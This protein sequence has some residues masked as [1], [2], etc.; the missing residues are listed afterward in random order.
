M[1]DAMYSPFGCYFGKFIDAFNIL[2]DHQKSE[3]DDDLDAWEVSVMVRARTPEEAYDKIVEI[4]QRDTRNYKGELDGVSIAWK[5][6]G[7]TELDPILQDP[8]M[9]TDFIYVE[10]HEIKLS[11]H[12]QNVRQKDE[13]CNP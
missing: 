7:I 3:F 2:E 1:S 11:E 5:F 6:A 12:L 4:A 10:H 13:L 9:D 8:C